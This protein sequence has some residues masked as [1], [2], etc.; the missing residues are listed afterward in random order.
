LISKEQHL[1]GKQHMKALKIASADTACGDPSLWTCDVCRTSMQLSSKKQHEAG[2]A[3]LKKVAEATSA[4]G[5]V[6]TN[7]SLWT[8]DVC[9]ATMQM[10]L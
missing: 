5:T 3:H 2:K 1:D 8:C 4:D 9:S 7:Q 10:V 6:E